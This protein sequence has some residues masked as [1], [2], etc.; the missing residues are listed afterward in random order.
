MNYRLI[1]FSGI[2]TAIIGGVLGVGFSHLGQP[3]INQY[4]YQTPIYRT[5]YN[6]YFW[7]GS[8]VGLLVGM[9]QECVRQSQKE[10]QKQLDNQDF[11]K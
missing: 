9:G 3:D 11:W 7:L 6:N 1:A 10:R 4:R 2:I 5:L 8:G